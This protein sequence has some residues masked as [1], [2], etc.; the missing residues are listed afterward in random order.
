MK[1][2]TFSIPVQLVQDATSAHV[3]GEFNNWTPNEAA[4]MCLQEDGSLAVTISL[5]IGKN[6]QYKFFLND[7]RWLNDPAAQGYQEQVNYFTAN[8]IVFVEAEAE[9]ATKDKAETTKEKNTP[10]QKKATPKKAAPKKAAAKKSASK[11]EIV[12]DPLENI[13]GINVATRN[14]LH[15]AGITTFSKLSKTGQA[16]I[17]AALSAAGEEFA[18]MDSSSWVRDAK[19]EAAEKAAAL[20]K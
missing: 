16:T 17:K 7:G 10:T 4:K 5:E 3:L 6:Y 19:K 20:K 14:V 15:N 8:S 2:V 11:K 9:Q 13:K 12:K 18:A 1:N